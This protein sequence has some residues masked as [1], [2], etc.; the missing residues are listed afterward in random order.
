MKKAMKNQTYPSFEEEKRLWLQN[1]LVI[2]VDEVGRGAFAGPIVAA[3]VVMPQGFSLPPQSLL[4]EVND[5]KQVKPLLRIKL[6][7]EIKKHASYWSI[8][9]VGVSIINTHGIGKA[10]KIAFRKVIGN[11]IKQARLLRPSQEFHL[12]VDGFHVKFVREIGLENQK[13]I[14]KG[15]Q[16]CFSIAAASIIA[17]VYRDRL[18]KRYHNKFPKFGFGRNKGYG[19]T[20]HRKA[21]SNYGLTR[22][23][24][25]AFC[26]NFVN[27]PLQVLRPQ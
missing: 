12:L 15:D 23:H 9:C 27:S 22:I 2:G 16:K 10:N 25:L 21:L 13:A 1:K 7:E 24:R 20:F 3:A 5:S 19:T 26:S 8:E 14:I 11:V 6:S 17:K 4:A 18:M